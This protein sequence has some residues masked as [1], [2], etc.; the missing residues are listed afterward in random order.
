MEKFSSKKKEKRSKNKKK[1][2]PILLTYGKYKFQIKDVY[3]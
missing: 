2:L 3:V 1:H